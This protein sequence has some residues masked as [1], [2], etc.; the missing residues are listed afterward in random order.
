[1]NLFYLYLQEWP[2]PVQ[3]VSLS[4]AEEMELKL[5]MNNNMFMSFD[6]AESKGNVFICRVSNIQ[7]IVFAGKK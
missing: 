4:T 2:R 3:V 1:M 7:A 6:S 5:E